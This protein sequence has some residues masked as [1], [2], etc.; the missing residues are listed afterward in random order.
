MVATNV[1]RIAIRHTWLGLVVGT[2]VGTFDP[3]FRGIVDW[4]YGIF[5][6]CF[7]GL[8][9]ECPALQIGFD[10]ELEMISRN[11]VFAWYV[12]LGAIKL[13]I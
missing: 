12:H 2:K 9:W 10:P 1:A 4:A 11:P 7:L 13:T 8:W 3:G 6:L 5:L